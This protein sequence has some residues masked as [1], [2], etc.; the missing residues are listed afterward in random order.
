MPADE[1]LTMWT[2]Y[3]HPLD[4]PD[5]FIAREWLIPP[6]GGEAVPGQ[7]TLR[8]QTIDDI[9]EQ[10]ADWGL[11]RLMRSPGDDPRIVESWL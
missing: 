9:R 6:G 5:V 1:A 11:V 7:R 3:D 8:A 4:A 10:L 2:V